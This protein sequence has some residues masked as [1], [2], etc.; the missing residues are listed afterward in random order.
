M[1]KEFFLSILEKYFK[2]KFLM[3]DALYKLVWLFVVAFS[4]VACEFREEIVFDSNGGGK[5]TSMFYGEQ[6]GEFLEKYLSEEG[7][8]SKTYYTLQELLDENKEEYSNFSEEDMKLFA[9]MLESNMSFE[10][11]DNDLYIRT[12]KTFTSLQE[13]NEAIQLSKRP[14]DQLLN[15]LSNNTKERTIDQYLD[16]KF[17]WKENSFERIVKVIDSVGFEQATKEYDDVVSMGAGFTY[18]LEYTF[19]YEVL[20]VFPE[21]VSLSLDRKTVILRRSVSKVVKDPTELNL[22]VTFKK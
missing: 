6:M 13:I 2:N 4:L 8:P 19:P 7:T 5:I 12:D 14:I 22:I 15:F 20:T 1:D 10:N 17:E 3:K 9:E 11:K 21:D 18:V 16:L